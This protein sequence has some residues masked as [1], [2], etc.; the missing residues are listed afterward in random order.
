MGTIL[1]IAFFIA[2]WW[3]SSRH[4]ESELIEF[5]GPTMGTTY[6]VKVFRAPDDIEPTALQTEIDGILAE[7][8]RQMSTYD[9]ESELS[10]FNRNHTTDWVPVSPE[11]HA[12]IQEALR[13]SHLT[14][15]AFDITVGP[16]V[17]LWGFGPE[18]RSGSIP[19]EE[20]IREAL[21]RVGYEQIH[22][23][24]SPPALRKD[25]P[26]I[27]LDLSAIAKGYAVDQVAAHLE[28]GDIRD[29]MVEIGGELRIKGHNAKGI[30]WQIAIEEPDPA[31][32]AVQRII[33]IT[34]EG[35]ATSGDY[36][37]FFEHEGQRYS[38]EI[39]PLTGWPVRHKL[40]SVTVV[41]KSCM[42]ADAFATAL[43]VM[44]PE[45]GFDL[46]EQEHLAVF[47]IIISNDDFQEKMTSEFKQ[48]LVK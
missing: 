38:H 45:K 5:S 14:D 3:Y 9:P 34:D 25:R 26:D 33:E 46:A 40:A 8:N 13:I 48:Y 10:R 39:D 30:P 17:N 18:T 28:A 35:I 43:I 47:F 22:I 21:A 29:Y 7:I 12:V 31:K 37:N 24:D 4:G 20:T 11:L 32:R 6:T 41:N 16:L 2:G 42:R 19:S 15:G 27:Y 1:L 44:G 23:R 36:R